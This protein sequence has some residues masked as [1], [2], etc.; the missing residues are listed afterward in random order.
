MG[1]LFTVEKIGIS[2]S[3][4]NGHFETNSIVSGVFFSN[5]VETRNVNG[6]SNSNSE[7]D[8]SV[9]ARLIKTRLDICTRHHRSFEP[10]IS[11][12]LIQV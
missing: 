7:N 6:S 11:T 4:P 1:L 9:F 10:S 3:K 5:R 2:V 12:E 8:L